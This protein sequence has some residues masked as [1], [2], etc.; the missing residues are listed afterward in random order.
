MRL[1]SR[2]CRAR[3]LQREDVR[4]VLHSWAGR[5]VVL[6]AKCLAIDGYEMFH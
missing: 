1:L 3:S 2:P 5:D 4:F 6:N